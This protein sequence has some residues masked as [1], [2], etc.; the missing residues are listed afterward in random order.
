MKK[1]EE[2]SDPL[3]MKEPEPKHLKTIGQ[4]MPLVESSG[5]RYQDAH[6]RDTEEETEADI[7]E[8]ITKK[9][10]EL[11]DPLLMKEPEPKHLKTS[12]TFIA[13]N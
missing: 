13:Q 10:E 2:S 7:L 9:Q 8:L 12:S 6:V 3:H 4:T 1:Q 5:L 11:S